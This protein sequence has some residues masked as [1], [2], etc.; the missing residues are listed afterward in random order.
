MTSTKFFAVLLLTCAPA[1]TACQTDG[2]G[3]PAASAQAEPQE[4]PKPLTRSEAAMQCW[5]SV[6]KTHKSAGLDQRADIVTKCID[7]KLNGPKQPAAASAKPP[8]P[9]T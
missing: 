3:T 4:P 8:K 2:A 9:Q 6:E 7:D 1:L 5:M